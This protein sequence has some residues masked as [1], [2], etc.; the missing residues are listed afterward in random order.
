MT[1][2]I[3]LTVIFIPRDGG[4]T[5]HDDIYIIIPVQVVFQHDDLVFHPVV[6]Q[7]TKPG[8]VACHGDAMKRSR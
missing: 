1:G 5:R 2:K 6:K 4:S 3:V 7:L 8:I